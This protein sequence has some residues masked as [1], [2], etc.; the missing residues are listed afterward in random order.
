MKKKKKNALLLSLKLIFQKSVEEGKI[1]EIWKTAH[2]ST[3]FKSG[4]KSKP[5]NYRSISLTS[6]P[7][8]LLE[9]LIRDEIVEHMTVNNLFAFLLCHNT[10]SVEANLA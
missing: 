2:V 6:V 7:G 5:E 1:P 8:K 10:A 4:S 3:I 9:R